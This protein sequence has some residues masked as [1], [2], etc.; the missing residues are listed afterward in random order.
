MCIVSVLYVTKLSGGLSVVKQNVD[1]SLLTFS[2]S[3]ENVGKVTVFLWIFS[4]LPGGLTNQLYFQ[5]VCAADDEKSVNKSLAISAV[6]LMLAFGWSVY[7]GLNIRSLNPTI[8][9]SAATGWFM[10]Q[11]P[12]PLLAAFAALIFATLMSTVSSGVQSAVVNITRDIVPV[13]K[14]NMS[15]QETLKL[16]RIL[17]LVTIMVALILCLFFSDTLKWLVT[18]YAFSAATLL[19][20]IYVGYLARNKNFLTKEGIVA[21]MIAGAIGCVVGMVLKTQINYAAIGIALSFIA[22]FVVS[23]MT[24]KKE[25]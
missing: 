4:V 10:T 6:L 8:E 2:G 5:R 14:P 23:A 21:S 12:L 15:E 16:S 13:I 22:L 17:S 1:P 3:I 19:C 20:P 24:R 9:G 25:N 11:L 7:M 18:T